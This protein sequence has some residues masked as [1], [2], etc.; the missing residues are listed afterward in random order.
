MLPTPYQR[1]DYYQA[2]RAVLRVLRGPKSSSEAYSLGSL[3]CA[4]G[5]KEEWVISVEHDV[6]L[7][8]PNFLNDGDSGRL[9]VVKQCTIPS[10][11]MILSDRDATD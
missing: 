10:L 11:P 4:L 6:P 5:P 1:T 7:M 3:L 2:I 9:D 8:V